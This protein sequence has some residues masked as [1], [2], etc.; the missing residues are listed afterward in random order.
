M[1]DEPEEGVFPVDEVQQLLADEDSTMNSLDVNDANDAFKAQV[2]VENLEPN[3]PN[4]SSNPNRECN[5]EPEVV[6]S[7]PSGSN[8]TNT[9]D[10][11]MGSSE[12]PNGSN[13]N[14]TSAHSTG[15]ALKCKNL[16]PSGS[17]CTNTSNSSMGLTPLNSNPGLK[18]NKHSA[19]GK[20]M[21]IRVLLAK[22]AANAAANPKD[23]NA[24]KQSPKGY[25]PTRGSLGKTQLP[26]K[27]P[28]RGTKPATAGSIA[29]DR[30]KRE[31]TKPARR[32]LM[33]D[34]LPSNF[35]NS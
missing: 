27:T 13:C 12:E 11:C 34:P 4:D 32:A 20:S 15:A 6:T 9:S 31:C 28:K 26:P 7:D 35:H 10:P 2:T 21:D 24:K 18:G 16:E 17:N 8:G 29:T 1:P 19:T 5:A 22:Q 14:N 33:L 30:P 23:L 3:E 25:P